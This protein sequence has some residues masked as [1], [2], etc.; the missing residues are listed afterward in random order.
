MKPR[1][2]KSNRNTISPVFDKSVRQSEEM[3]VATMRALK[4]NDQAKRADG[5]A[6]EGTVFDDVYL[7]LVVLGVYFTAAKWP[8]FKLKFYGPIKVVGAN[9]PR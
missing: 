9:H 3:A 2:L 7:V 6:R 1:T 5:N 8:V 4:T